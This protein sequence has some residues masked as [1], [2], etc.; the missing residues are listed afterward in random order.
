MQKDEDAM[1]GLLKYKTKY[2]HLQGKRIWNEL[3][4][5][6]GIWLQR[7]HDGSYKVQSWN[8]KEEDSSIAKVAKIKL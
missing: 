4:F 3:V 8:P 7:R 2:K 5:K 1:W 6:I